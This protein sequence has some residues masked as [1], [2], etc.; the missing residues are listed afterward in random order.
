MG[1]FLGSIERFHEDASRARGLDDFGADDYRE[2]LE[3]LCRSLDEQVRLTPDGEVAFEAMIADALQARLLCEQGRRRH[4]QAEDFLVERPLVIVG[5]PRTGT[6]A[7]HHLIARDP[8]FQALE[9]WLMRT[10]KPR[11]ARAD[12]ETD[13]DFQASVARVD[14]MFARSPEMRAIHE[15]EAH[16]PDECWNLFSQNFMH[17]SY[18]ANGDVPGYAEWWPSQSFAP[19]Y[20]RHR[21]N[22]QL[23]GHQEPGRRFVF[24]DSTHLFDLPALLSVYPDAMIVQT[25]RDPVKLIP[26]VCSL[27]W[28]ARD[29]LMVDPDP[30]SLGRSTLALWER[31]IESMM[32]AREGR[33]PDQ[34]FDLPFER[35]VQ[36][37]LRAIR[38]IYGHFDLDY[39]EAAESAIEAFRASNPREKHADHA[40]SAQDWGLDPHQIADRFAG[41]TR[42]F[43][44]QAET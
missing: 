16:L 27:C 10:P 44:I 28:T 19:V 29:A 26:S 32:Q 6:T 2:A 18:E 43:Q 33:D 41:Y 15:I 36:D 39:S 3:V 40:Y 8:G 31:G 21:R 7:L 37:P 34:F 13:P 22:A 30:K 9:H 4:P 5:L 24:K 25:H 14:M 35:F 42:A 11:P 23:I 20:A 1:E 12:W 38:S 17:C